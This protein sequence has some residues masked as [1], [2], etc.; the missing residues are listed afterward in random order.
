MELNENKIDIWA[1]SET[2]GEGNKK[3]YPD[4]LLYVTDRDNRHGQA[5]GLN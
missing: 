4:Y 5:N 1:L 2:K 3:G